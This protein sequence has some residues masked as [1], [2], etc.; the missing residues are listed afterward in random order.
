MVRME[1]ACIFVL[2][3]LA[4]MY[5]SAR[6]ENN[7]LHTCFSGLLVLSIIHL[8]L[9]TATIY[10]VNHMDT[11]PISI[12]NIVHRYFYATMVIVFYITYYYFALS[13]RQSDLDHKHSEKHANSNFNKVCFY[14]NLFMLIACLLL[15][16]RYVKTPKGNY[17]FGPAAFA[18]YVCLVIDLILIVGSFIRHWGCLNHKE[19]ITLGIA[20][21]ILTAGMI[22]QM[23]MP[24]ALISGMGITLI[25]LAIYLNLENPD[26]SL[27]QQIAEEK[28]KADAANSAKSTFL[29][30][31]SHE[32]RTPM[33]AI[34]G[35]SEILLREDLTDE[36][37]EYLENINSSG[38]ALVSIVND[39][40]DIS[41]I[42][43]GKMELIDDVYDVK[44][45][46]KD[47]RIIIMNR[48]GSKQV[49]LIYDID[50]SVPETLYGDGLR[51]R[52][53]IINLMNNA[54]KFTD[55]GSVTLGIHVEEESDED[56]RLK[57]SVADT[58]QGIH[59]EDM[60]RLFGEFQQVDQKKNHNKEGTGL[61]LSIS[62]QLVEL[63]DGKITVT[64]EYGVGSEFSFTISQKKVTNEMI[65][66]SEVDN[67]NDFTAK[68]ARILIVDDNEINRM[69]A[70][71]L[72]SRTEMEILSVEN[73]EKAL[74]MIQDSF[75]NN[76]PF[77]VVFMDQ[78]MPGM[79]GDETTKALR[80]LAGEYYQALPII[81][82]TG[83][84]MEEDKQRFAE[85]GMNDIVTKPINMHDMNR[86]LRKWLPSNKITN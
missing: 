15:P 37:H 84:A 48:I 85:A 33:N 18:L 70:T 38:I 6:R 19:R 50:E 77:D 32:I 68:D 1:I 34:V 42:E 44:Q 13:V 21:F 28:K 66:Q 17:S 62:M 74:A 79:N 7:E 65:S 20:I 35:I 23:I 71:T 16:I 75:Q 76:Q 14:L 73:G 78:M 39:I 27:V 4:A 24:L 46:L 60:E 2:L 69:V 36:Q 8:A 86:V 82:L 11:I 57:V 61:G 22:T 81:A 56:Y 47:I 67:C 54:V 58:G 80:A 63:M 40:L 31:M 25:V 72:L 5:F 9:D 45:M 30:H 53:I 41:K 49:Q 51:I 26:I 59:P 64:S 10:T 55:K 43:A 83:D 3:I 12:N 52:Q 29:A